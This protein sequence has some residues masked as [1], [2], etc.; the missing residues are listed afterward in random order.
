MRRLDWLLVKAK[1][2]AGPVKSN[3]HGDAAWSDA[4]KA[5]SRKLRPTDSPYRP[6]VFALLLLGTDSLNANRSSPRRA[7]GRHYAKGLDITPQSYPLDVQSAYER[8]DHV[9]SLLPE[10]EEWETPVAATK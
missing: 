5:M 3:Q 9:K 10:A 2:A 8:E 4:A 1:A 7:R 6:G